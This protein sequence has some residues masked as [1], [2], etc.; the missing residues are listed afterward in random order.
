M[1]LTRRQFLGRGVVSAAALATFGPRLRWLPGTGVSWAACTGD[2]NLVFVQLYGGNDGINTVYPI[3]GAERS[4]YESFRP[5]LKLPRTAGEFDPAFVATF[6]SSSVLSVG[7]NANGSVYAL[8]PAMG[9]LHTLYGQGRLAIVN[10]VHYPF[11]DHS[12]FR[13]EV[14]WY[15]ADPLGASGQGWFGRF[16][17]Y[18]GCYARTDVPAVMMGSD[19][20]P[21]FTPTQTSLFAL[22]RLSELRFPASGELLRKQATFLQ[23]YDES[24]DRDPGLFPELVSIGNTGVA[25][26][27]KMQDYFRPGGGLANAGKVEAL[28]LDGDG[29]YDPDNDLVYASPLNP[30]TNPAIAEMSLAR[31]LKHVAAMI[32]ADVGARFFHVAIGGFDSHSNQE[33]DFFHSFLLREVSESI[34]AFYND[35]R[36][37]VTLPSG[38]SGYKTGDLSAKVLVVV[39]SEFGR[40]IRQNAYDPGAAGTDHATSN[41]LFVLGGTVL[42]GQHHGTYPLLDDPG[43]NEDDLRMTYDFRDVFG[44]V[45]TRW[46]GVPVVDL[47][48]GPSKLLPAT[49]QTDPLGNDYV[50]FTPIGFLP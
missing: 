42:G 30:S 11:A 1:A 4:K 49:P 22:N 41:P 34:A 48:P 20:N 40:T 46:L 33:K 15:T 39:F 3:G 24:N 10:G 38:Y 16:L 19:L 23:L 29:D 8:H 35:V 50:T 9:A 5:T 13:S 2:A 14:I 45:L 25:T 21:L 47:G 44:T 6:G 32:R 12:H 27:E 36:Q 7:A 17:D 18:G 26:V 28:L 43:E 31:D 37:A